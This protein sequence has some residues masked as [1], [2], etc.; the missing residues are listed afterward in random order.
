MA[1]P[2]ERNNA[3]TIRVFRDEQKKDVGASQSLFEPFVL[4]FP[5][6]GATSEAAPG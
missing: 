3:R 4:T 5:A 1:L 2:R 6:H